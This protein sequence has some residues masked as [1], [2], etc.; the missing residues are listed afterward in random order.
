MSYKR[1][2]YVHEYKDRHGRTRIYYNRPG[3]KKVALRGPVGSKEFWIDYHAT[4]QGTQAPKAIGADKILP[5]SLSDLV[6]RYYRDP[7]YL[8]LAP[9]TQVVVRRQLDA[10]CRE[11]DRGRLPIKAFQRKHMKTVLSKMAD[12][13]GAANNLLKRLKVLTRFAVEIGML[14][15]DPLL[16]MRGFKYEAKSFHTW[17][18]QDVDKFT[19]RHPPGTKAYLAMTLMLCTGQRLSD[20]AVMGWK[21]VDGE[22]IAAKQQ[23]TKAF[24]SIPLHDDLRAEIE[25]LD[26]DAPAFLMTEKGR[27][28]TAKGLGNWMRDRCDEAGLPECSSHGL[29]SAMASR[30]AEAGCSAKEVASV[31]GHTTLA[32][33][34]LYT[35]AAEQK[36]LSDNA[37]KALNKTQAGTKS[38][39]PNPKVS[40]SAF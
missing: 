19:A 29:R 39:N 21:S 31:T 20:A 8:S 33:V 25:P 5:G 18:T 16:G 30:L 32:Q 17:T 27:P 9:P 35:K 15:I 13:Q 1:P 28:F 36:V 14:Q 24:I 37:M 4:E 34:A 7:L 26:R 6:A 22:R 11:N 10:F 3:T 40:K 2:K 23:K 12:R 38:A